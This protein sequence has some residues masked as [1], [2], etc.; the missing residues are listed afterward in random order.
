[1]SNVYL[2]HFS[3]PFGHAQHYAGVT[4]RDDIFERFDEHRAGRG[5]RLCAKAVQAG[6]QLQLA[7]V[8]AN[9]ERKFELKIKGRGLRAICPMCVGWEAASRERR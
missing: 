8:W 5:A 1:M 6:I 2:I 4:N 3:K 9:V 7:R